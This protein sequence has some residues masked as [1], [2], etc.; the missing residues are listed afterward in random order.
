MRTGWSKREGGRRKMEWTRI[1]EGEERAGSRR[2]N[3]Q[4]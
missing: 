2:G 3:G 4:E 1:G